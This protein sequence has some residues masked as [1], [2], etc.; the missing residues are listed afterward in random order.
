MQAW[1]EGSECA[2]HREADDV[3]HQCGFPSPFV[4]DAAEDEGANKAH[5]QGEEQRIGHGR[6]INAEFLGNIGNEEGEQEEVEGVE[7]PAEIGGQH[8]FFLRGCQVHAVLQNF[9]EG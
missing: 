8:G 9:L 2:Q 3:E 7:S 6:H 5:R 1:R 4:A